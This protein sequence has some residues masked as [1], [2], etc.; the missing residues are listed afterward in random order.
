MG[1]LR[2]VWRLALIVMAALL[3][4]Q[5]LALGLYHLQRSQQA[6]MATGQPLAAQVATLAR[7][8][9]RLDPDARGLALG[10]FGGPGMAVAVGAGM[11]AADPEGVRLPRLEQAI[12]SQLVPGDERA[13]AA[14][15]PGQDR[16]PLLRRLIGG[17][18]RIE[19]AIAGGA[20]LRVDAHGDLTLRILGIPVGVFA[21]LIGLAV[22]ALALFAVVRETR[23]LAAL[24]LSLERFGHRPEAAPPLAEKGAP[25]VR[26]LIRAFNAMQGR[27]LGLMRGRALVLGAVSHDL[28]TSLTRL[29]LRADTV[30]EPATRAAMLRDVEDMEALLEDSL[31]FA[32]AT[33]AEEGGACDLV[34][35]VR[36]ECEEREALG[37]PVTLD[38]RAGRAQVPG[39]APALR[40]VVANLVDNA[41]KYGGRAD[42]VL[43]AAD[44]WAEL[45]VDDAGPG[46]PEAARAAVFEPFRRL[47]QSRNRELGGAGLGLTIA[48][49][50]V[51]SLGGTIAVGS[52]PGGGARLSIR[53]PLIRAEEGAAITK[54]VS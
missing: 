25:D 50:I 18:V 33:F 21:G 6:D 15:V 51:G 4:V 11:P 30:A 9:D 34:R 40:R 8:I 24:A 49:Q 23:P 43:T 29:R 20:T 1:R 28:R 14:W 16:F 31:A 27:I 37:E 2:F 36:R 7:L 13:V 48:A 41:V 26:I 12:R 17:I 54:Q 47:E 10:A 44:G 19:I 38:D 39:T 46:I 32:R 3:V 53:L 42:L 35:V 22:A 45:R 5:F 52:S